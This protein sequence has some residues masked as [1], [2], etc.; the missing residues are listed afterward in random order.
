MTA[1]ADISSG[2]TTAGKMNYDA[3]QR[4]INIVSDT[5][6]VHFLYCAIGFLLATILWFALLLGIF[7]G[8]WYR[9]R[10]ERSWDAIAKR[11]QHVGNGE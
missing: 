5:T 1:T 6:H 9:K 10:T 8:R 7:I 3:I 11:Y 2:T 4:A